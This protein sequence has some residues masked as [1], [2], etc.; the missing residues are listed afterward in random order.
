MPKPSAVTQLLP[1]PPAPFQREL[2]GREERGTG[3]GETERSHRYPPPSPEC[4]MGVL[5][6]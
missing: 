1:P 4:D 5:E 6:R 3:E 2:G